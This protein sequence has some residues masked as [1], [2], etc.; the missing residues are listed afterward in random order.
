MREIYL[1]HAAT[2]PIEPKARAAMEKYW[3]EEFGNPGSFHAAGLRAQKALNN[4]RASVA[5]ILNCAPEEV[6]FTG[7]GT[8][9]INMAIKGI[10]RAN[11]A[12]GKHIITSATE[13]HAVLETCRYLHKHDGAE[14]TILPVNKY[15]QVM[16]ETLEKAIR[17]D[18]VLVTIHYANNEIG[19]INRI[20]E[21][22][23]I[24]RKHNAL[25]HTDACQAAGS[26]D[27]DVQTLGVDLLT[28]NGSKVYGPK[29]VGALY[30][31]RGT[32]I[33]PILHG[34]GQEFGLRSGTEN[35]PLIVGF[36]TALEIAHQMREKEAE[37]LAKLRDRLISTILKTI[38]KTFLNGHPTERLPNNANITFLDIEGEALLL[39]LNEHG[40]CASTGSACSSKSL[41]PSHVIL[42]L[43]LP[44]EASHGS[45]RF[46]LGRHTAEEDINKVLDVLPGIV[47][48]LRNISPVNLNMEDMLR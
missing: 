35:I 43:G 5:K 2:T 39:H 31:R 29:G 44:Y 4:S 46:T 40:I 13:H 23:A 22:A 3:A 34:G 10:F 15:G 26:L 48:K 20:K 37:R 1:D 41:E 7:S 8:E 27:L 9:S 14:L 21:L 17:P 33:H 12:K 30:I 16:P 28:L 42:A 6:I 11:K 24:A 32:N 38:P 45:I 19:T 47:Q 18:T 36:A 25:F